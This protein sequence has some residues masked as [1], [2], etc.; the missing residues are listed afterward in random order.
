MKEEKKRIFINSLHAPDTF[1]AK[2][3][4]KEE[5]QQVEICVNISQQQHVP[6]KP[7]WGLAKHPC[8]ESI[9]SGQS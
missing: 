2:W 4:V 5:R 9:L 7:S 3:W 1:P 8:S 6:S